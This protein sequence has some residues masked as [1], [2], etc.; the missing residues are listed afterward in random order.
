MTATTTQFKIGFLKM[1]SVADLKFGHQ[2]KGAGLN[3]RQYGRR[4]IASLAHSIETFGIIVPFC[5]KRVDGVAYI[6]DGNRRLA[7]LQSLPADKRPAAV[8][9]YE[10]DGE[11]LELSMIA[12]VE[13]LD[14]HPVDRFEV[15]A[16]LVAGG[17]TVEALADRYLMKVPQVRQALSLAR[18]APEIRQ[19][20]RDGEI[21][22][23]TAEAFTQSSSQD[24]QTKAFHKLKKGRNLTEWAVTRE[25]GVNNSDIGPMLKLVGQETYERAGHQVNR[26]LFSGEAREHDTVSDIHALKSMVGNVIANECT[27]LVDDGWAWAIPKTEA[28]NDLYAWRKLPDGKPTKEQKANAGCVVELS[29]T[30]KLGVT[31][32]YIKPG[33]TVKIPKSAE[34]KK[35]DTKARAARK[36]ETGGISSVLAEKLSRQITAA[37]TAALREDGQLALDVVIA[38]LAC[39]NAPL[40]IDISGS[41]SFPL[42]DRADNDFSKYLALILRKT[43]KQKLELL[44]TWAAPAIDMVCYTGSGL[45]L[46][47]E[48]ADGAGAALLNALA[49][50][51]LNAALREEFDA[52]DYFESVSASVCFAAIEEMGYTTPTTKTM[53]KAAL[54]KAAA[55]A[56]AV[57]RK[58]LPPEMRT[59]HYPGPGKPAGKA[60][61]R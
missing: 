7:A 27:R 2:L 35:A 4:E 42:D 48:H 49:P 12:N 24:L 36:A 33:T 23:A 46:T 17:I 58:W 56:F 38:A 10:A 22:A 30:G 9:T 44:A 20:W 25:L 47:G 8:P 39:A 15:F 60:K 55:A 28:P 61:A 13:R 5:I 26:S 59:K 45:P 50:V 51:K 6:I 57:D 21:D 43:P 14:L 52:K 31:H 34:Q 3:A 32:G 53:K 11:G 16:A 41:G 29:Y 19:A 1:V 37:A 40:G 18:M 54:A